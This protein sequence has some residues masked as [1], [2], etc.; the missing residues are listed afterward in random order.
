MWL[1]R[2]HDDCCYGHYE[3]DRLLDAVS[4]DRTKYVGPT[5]AETLA[6]SDPRSEAYSMPYVYDSFTWSHCDEDFLGSV[7]KAYETKKSK[8][9]LQKA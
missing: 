7:T 2:Y 3:N 4:G 1:H 6:A 5:N 9:M 8:K